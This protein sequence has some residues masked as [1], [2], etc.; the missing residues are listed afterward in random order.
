M[1]AML[2]ARCPITKAVIETGVESD[3]DSLVIMAY[4]KCAVYCAKCGHHHVMRVKEMYCHAEG[5]DI[6]A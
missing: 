3:D 1:A 6:A 4:S 2:Y 5:E